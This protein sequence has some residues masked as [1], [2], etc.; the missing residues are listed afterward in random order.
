VSVRIRMKKIGRSHQ[1]FFRICAIDKRSPRHG[2]VLE[3]LGTYDPRVK[4]TDARALLVADRVDY[5]LGVGAQPSERVAVLIKKYGTNGTHISA[6]K[7][8]LEKIAQPKTVPD[9]GAPASLPIPKPKKGEAPAAA[10]EAEAEPVGA[11]ASAEAGGDG[12]AQSE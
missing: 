10:P 11:G 6:Q 3:H 8:A 7:A 9:A 1:S 4:D 5:W 12:A 2:R